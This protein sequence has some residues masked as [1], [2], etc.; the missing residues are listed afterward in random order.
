MK[1]ITELFNKY[2]W[3]S[4]GFRLLI[5][6]AVTL[7]FLKWVSWSYKKGLKLSGAKEE[8]HKK[9]SYQ[10]LRCITILISLYII[11]KQLPFTSEFLKFLGTSSSLLIAI[12]GFAAQAALSNMLSGIFISFS[13]PFNIGDR[14]ILTSRNITGIVEDINIRHTV[15][16][17]VENTRVLI[18][19]SIMNTEIIENSDFVDGRVCNFLDVSVAYEADIDKARDIIRD[20]VRH[21]RYFLDYRTEE[22][23]A[24][25]RDDVRVLVRN[26]G[27]SGVDLRCSVWTRTIS[28]NFEM[29]SELRHDIL[30]AFNKEGIEIPYPHVQVLTNK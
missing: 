28:E 3:V 22:D 19:N 6:C 11:M 14:V 20:L 13:K 10:M 9:F 16:R 2:D 7:I 17:T 1:E 8:I 26:L 23:K 5:I 27:D 24:N 4:I 12:L 15:I 30:I 25:G 21:H 29:C 18:P